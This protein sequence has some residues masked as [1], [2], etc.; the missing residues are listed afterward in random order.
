MILRPQPA[1][2]VPNRENALFT[3]GDDG[4]LLG[5]NISEPVSHRNRTA[6]PWESEEHQKERQTERKE[7][8][9]NF[10]SKK[11]ENGSGWN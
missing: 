8:K 4:T 10:H 11:K 6:A 9:E 3:I 1:V 5:L 2:I 7:G